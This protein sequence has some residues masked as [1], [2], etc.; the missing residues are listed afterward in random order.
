MIL[1][2]DR[3]R[4]AR[5][6][7][8]VLVAA[9]LLTPAL[10]LPYLAWR[11]RELTEAFNGYVGWANILA[12]TAGA[13]GIII[14]V[15]D[16][17]ASLRAPTEEQL[18]RGVDSIAHVAARQDQEL[19]A[20]LLRTDIPEIRSANFR[21]MSREKRSKKEKRARRKE[22]SFSDI[23]SYFTSQTSR[24]L[25]ILGAAG[26]GK[27]ILALTLS[28][29]LL[30]RLRASGGVIGSVKTPVPIFVSAESWSLATN[31]LDEWFAEQVAQRFRLAN[32]FAQRVVESRRVFPV[33]DGLDE[34]DD[35][36]DLSNPRAQAAIDR[37]NTYI[38]LT[39]GS[40][41]VIASRPIAGKLDLTSR[42]IRNA[43]VVSIESITPAGSSST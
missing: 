43:D 12:F 7:A 13:V 41:V 28:T 21:F 36:K 22:N 5:I 8:W 10:I 35:Q 24:R 17:I 11:D 9:A 25:V 6:V 1:L 20:Q 39:P 18:E 32:K 34:M 14:L 23:E 15:A 37:I 30:E 3:F 42:Q 27:T 16:R 33:I 29:R 40:H 19:L 26:S 38:A 4:M 31:D 2:V